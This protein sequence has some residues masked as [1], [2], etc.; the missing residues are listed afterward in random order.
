VSRRPPFTRMI[1][2]PT[3]SERTASVELHRSVARPACESVS[4]RAGR[5]FAVAVVGS[6]RLRAARGKSLRRRCGPHGLA[7]SGPI[8]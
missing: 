6:A 3:S 8:I 1:K 7:S 5:F 4:L 2:G